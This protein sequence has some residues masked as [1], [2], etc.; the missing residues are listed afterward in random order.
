MAQRWLLLRFNEKV[1]VKI[2]PLQK[3]LLFGWLAMSRHSMST[4]A[5]SP[6]HVIPSGLPL[7]HHL[8]EIFILHRF[9]WYCQK[10][11]TRVA[12]SYHASLSDISA[13][14]CLTE[15]RRYFYQSTLHETKLTKEIITSK[16]RISM[17]SSDMG[18]QVWLT[19]QP[20]SFLYHQRRSRRIRRRKKGAEVRYLFL[21]GED[22]PLSFPSFRLSH[23]V[24]GNF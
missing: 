10:V 20:S 24:T 16:S 5:L 21:L 2:L 13:V 19:L 17:V 6:C 14:T 22:A 15:T 23:G 3:L 18:R 8:R 11:S 7:S 9:Q 4:W 1:W 12:F